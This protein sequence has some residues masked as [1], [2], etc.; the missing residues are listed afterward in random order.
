MQ[1]RDYI[2]AKRLV[3]AVAAVSQALAALEQSAEN[4]PAGSPTGELASRSTDRRHTDGAAPPDG[5]HER[6][7]ERTPR[8][9]L[10]PF[11]R[12][13]RDAERLVKIGWST[14]EKHTYEH[15]VAVDVVRDVCGFLADIG[16]EQRVFK[17]E[18]LARVKTADGAEIPSYQTYLVLKW[19][20]HVGAVDRRGNDGYVVKNGE[21]SP[22]RVEELWLATPNRAARQ[23][24]LQPRTPTD[25]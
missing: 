16:T 22:V 23:P 20:Q 15:R 21:L 25:K 18:K 4:A 12:F 8:A 5:E 6:A 24:V 7:R 14:K 9:Q 11:P 17:I 1:S 2:D 10:P 13:E 3:D 19:L